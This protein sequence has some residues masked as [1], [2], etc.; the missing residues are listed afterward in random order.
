MIK[1]KKNILRVMF[2]TQATPVLLNSVI[3]QCY[4][5]PFLK[6]PYQT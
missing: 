4:W 3:E 6:Y 5:T 2:K 1:K